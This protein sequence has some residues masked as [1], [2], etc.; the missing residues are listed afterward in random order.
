MEQWNQTHPK[1]F[2][3]KTVTNTSRSFW[4]PRIWT[5]PG[6]EELRWEQWAPNRGKLKIPNFPVTDSSGILEFFFLIIPCKAKQSFFLLIPCELTEGGKRAEGSEL[7]LFLR[8]CGI[9]WG[10]QKQKPPVA[11]SLGG[12]GENPFKIRE[13]TL[14]HGQKNPEFL[15][16][17]LHC[18]DFYPGWVFMSWNISCPLCF[19][20]ILEPECIQTWP[21]LGKIIIVPPPNADSQSQNCIG[22]EL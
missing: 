5:E 6:K 22:K 4:I 16:L 15:I 13:N 7:T 12:A 21:F 11:P 1:D 9:R 10:P 8:E 20:R 18:R 19:C 3:G 14:K 17:V 2:E